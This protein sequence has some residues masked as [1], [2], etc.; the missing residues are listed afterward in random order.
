MLGTVP[1][2]Q[3]GSLSWHLPEHLSGRIRTA[4]WEPALFEEF[5]SGAGAGRGKN[6][7]L[8]A[9]LSQMKGR[10]VAPP[11]SLA[12][13]SSNLTREAARLTR[14]AHQNPLV[15]RPSPGAA[16]PSA[17]HAQEALQPRTLVRANA[18]R[19]PCLHVLSSGTREPGLKG[20]HRVLPT[21]MSA[22]NGQLLLNSNWF[23]VTSFEIAA[24][25]CSFFQLNLNNSHLTKLKNPVKIC[26][27]LCEGDCAG[28]GQGWPERLPGG[29]SE[30]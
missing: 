2:H 4:P 9:V 24:A 7:Q 21:R 1:A 23:W 29:A 16:T 3:P 28:R 13:V 5:P 6:D 19:P 8:F 17:A 27:D 15:P 26:S 18:G 14:S 10:S 12:A 22:L 20:P 30:G 25:F 11:A